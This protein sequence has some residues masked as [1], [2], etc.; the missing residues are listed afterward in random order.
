MAAL[1]PAFCV[2]FPVKLLEEIKFPISKL[3]EDK[4]L[5]ITEICKTLKI[6]RSTFYRYVQMK[7]NE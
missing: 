7:P 5:S 6:S 2:T 4:S 1:G 3:H